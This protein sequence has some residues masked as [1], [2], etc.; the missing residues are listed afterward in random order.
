M[1]LYRFRWRAKD[2]DEESHCKSYPK[3]Q[4][5]IRL[6][7]A[8]NPGSLIKIVTYR[9]TLDFVVAFKR[10]FISFKNM[11]SGFIYG[12]RP[13]IGLD[14]CHLK[15]LH[16]GVLVVAIFWMGIMAYSMFYWVLSSENKDTWTFFVQCLVT[17]LGANSCS[18]ID[19][20][21]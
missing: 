21:D 20:K 4:M 12:Y 14:G 16:G 3:L 2:K 13:F 7:R 1:Q 18:I 15:E 8:T 6:I 17:I 10:L 9:E 11:K 19:F 5:Y